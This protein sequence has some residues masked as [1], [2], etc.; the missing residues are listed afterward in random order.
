MATEKLVSFL[1]YASST[2]IKC[3]VNFINSPI[4]N[5]GF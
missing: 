5:H 2:S 1:W 3:K 4:Q